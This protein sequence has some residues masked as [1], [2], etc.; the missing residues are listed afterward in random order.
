[1]PG[2]LFFE[3]LTTDD[4]TGMRRFGTFPDSENPVALVE[5]IGLL[6]RYEKNRGRPATPLREREASRS[7]WRFGGKRLQGVDDRRSIEA[8]G[9]ADHLH[10]LAWQA[11]WLGDQLG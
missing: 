1:M 4:Q 8:L 5:H 2:A 6:L 3:H 10:G 7:R 9:Q 11:S